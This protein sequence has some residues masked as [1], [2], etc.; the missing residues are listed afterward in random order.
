MPPATGTELGAVSVPGPKLTVDAGGV[1]QHAVVPGL[2][3]DAYTK[4]TVDSSGHVTTG[5]FL[6]GTDI[7]EHSAD[8]ITSGEF[9]VN[10]T[11]DPEGNI[12]GDVLAIPDNGITARH[13]RDYTTALMQEENP[14]S[15][16]RYGDPHFLGRYWFKP[17]TSQLYIYSRGSAGLLWLPVG[18]GVLSQQNLRVGG[19][20]KATDSTIGTVTKYGT[21]LGFVAGEPIPLAADEYVGIYLVCEEAGNAVTVPNATGVEHQTGDWIVCLGA[22]AGWVHLDNNIGDGGGGGG[23]A[24][25]LNDLLDVSL[26]DGTL[27]MSLTPLPFAP[28]Q[29]GQILKYNATDGMWRNS[30]ILDGGVF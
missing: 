2:V 18:F 26:N 30:S 25:E 12:Y 15:I 29:D 10:E 14:G 20:Y 6:S 28:L 17:S 21:E 16:D 5:E 1:L 8:L 7:P 23:G 9:P 3:V 24:Q 11:V 4:V 13:I 19:T 27:D 22:A